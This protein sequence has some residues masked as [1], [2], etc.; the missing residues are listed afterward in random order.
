MTVSNAT[1]NVQQLTFDNYR[2]TAI[3]TN[4]NTK[5]TNDNLARV[6]FKQILNYDRMLFN[7][8]ML[9]L[10]LCCSIFPLKL[11]FKNF[12]WQTRAASNGMDGRHMFM[13]VALHTG[14]IAK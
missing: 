9:I 12:L 10:K 11:V 7:R 8:A 13:L 3:Q 1:N 5:I 2:M 4:K 6:L 14:R